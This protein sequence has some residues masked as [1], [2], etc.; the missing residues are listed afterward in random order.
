[1]MQRSLATPAPSNASI[2]ASQ[3]TVMF[4]TK[5][6]LDM[7]AGGCPTDGATPAQIRAERQE[8]QQQYTAAENGCNAVQSGGRRCVAHNHFGLGGAP[9]SST[10]AASARSTATNVSSLLVNMT[11]KSSLLAR[12]S[13]Q[14]LRKGRMLPPLSSVN[15][16]SPMG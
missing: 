12:S 8:R 11:C 10:S 13:V 6:V 4:M 14:R 3:E 1:M 2:T 9:P 5:T 15:T 7:I 16:W